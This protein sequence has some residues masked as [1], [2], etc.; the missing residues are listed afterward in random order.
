MEERITPSCPGTKA[1][2]WHRTTAMVTAG[3]NLVRRKSQV[4]NTEW[5]TGFTVALNVV[6]ARSAVLT[7]EYEIGHT[8]NSKHHTS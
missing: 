1:D 6:I 7:R 5:D 3:E 2:K 8:R 4:S